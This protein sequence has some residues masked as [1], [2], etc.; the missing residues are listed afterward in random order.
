MTDDTDFST[1]KSFDSINLEELSNVLATA[2]QSQLGGIPAVSV[3]RLEH[4]K[5]GERDNNLLIQFLVKEASFDASIL[6]WM[7]KEP[8]QKEESGFQTEVK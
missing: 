7:A 1:V 6:R 4:T 2:L 8:T 5:P 3:A